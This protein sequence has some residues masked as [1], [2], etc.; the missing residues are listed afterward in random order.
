MEIPWASLISFHSRA[1]SE[2]RGWSIDGK[3]GLLGLAEMLDFGLGRRFGGGLF[4][5]GDRDRTR[6]IG[7]IFL[8]H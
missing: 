1:V 3:L 6:L 8:F 5:R 2:S 7:G 4:P